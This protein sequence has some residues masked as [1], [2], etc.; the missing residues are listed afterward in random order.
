MK[1][2]T[3]Y[4]DLSLREATILRIYE[5]AVC[6]CNEY[7]KKVRSGEGTSHDLVRAAWIYRKYIYCVDRSYYFISQC[8]FLD[9][10]GSLIPA[11]K[12]VKQV[13]RD[14]LSIAGVNRKKIKSV[15]KGGWMYQLIDNSI[16]RTVWNN[17]FKK[18]VTKEM[19]DFS[20]SADLLDAGYSHFSTRKDARVDDR[21]QIVVIE[22]IAYDHD[23]IITFAIADAMGN[24]QYQHP[25]DF[26]TYRPI[27][28]DELR[29][30]HF[31]WHDA[32]EEQAEKYWQV[33]MT[34]EEKE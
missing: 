23:P 7:V 19:Y 34:T 27:I 30:I 29:D 18:A 10:K 16:G 21:G 2:Y 8:A 14:I 15:L 13:F 17:E 25:V 5:M 3:V 6:L 24:L 12:A 28:M 26:A 20:H 33:R 9:P 32:S 1:D 11:E 4:K 22:F 31:R